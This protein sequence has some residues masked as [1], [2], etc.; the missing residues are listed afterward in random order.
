MEITKIKAQKTLRIVFTALGLS[1]LLNNLR[2]GFNY[3][4]VK[5]PLTLPKVLRTQNRSAINTTISLDARIITLNLDFVK[6]N[7]PFHYKLLKYYHA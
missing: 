7:V 3:C 6:K 5:F 2:I 4:N 1:Y